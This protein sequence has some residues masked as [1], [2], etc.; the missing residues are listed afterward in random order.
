MMQQI[1]AVYLGL[2]RNYKM[3]TCPW[4]TALEALA[5]RECECELDEPSHSGWGGGWD[6]PATPWAA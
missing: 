6:D 4:E 1:V 5:C 3:Q 2:M